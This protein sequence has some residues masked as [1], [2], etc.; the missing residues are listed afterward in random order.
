MFVVDKNGQRVHTDDPRIDPVWDKC[1][2]LGIP[3]LIHTGEPSPFWSPWDRHNER[4]LELKQYPSRRRSDPRFA[5]FEVTME[6]QVVLLLHRDLE[7][8]GIAPGGRPRP[9]YSL[10]SSQ[11]SLYLSAVE[12]RRGSPVWISTGSFNLAHML[13]DLVEARIVDVN[14]LL[15]AVLQLHAEVLE[16]LKPCAPL[17]TSFWSERR[18]GRRIIRIVEP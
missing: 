11:R 3:V 6:E 7:G 12:E 18:R 15:F 5:S 16:D 4:W 10:S 1:A 13:E 8:G 2:E 17:S 14:A 9:G